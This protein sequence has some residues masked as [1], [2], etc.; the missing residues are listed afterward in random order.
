MPPELGK[1]AAGSHPESFNDSGHMF[2]EGGTRRRCVRHIFVGKPT[3]TTM[4]KTNLKKM[5]VTPEIQVL[6][7]QMRKEVLT[8]S[9]NAAGLYGAGVD[10]S[11]ADNN[12]NIW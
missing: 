10:D 12:G 9:G 8:I 1:K 11:N 4:A 3:Q 6:R 2:C 7:L 5:Y